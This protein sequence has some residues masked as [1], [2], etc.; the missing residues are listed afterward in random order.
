MKMKSN[1]WRESEIMAKMAAAKI[2]A[3]GESEMAAKMA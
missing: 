2:M 3:G 1:G